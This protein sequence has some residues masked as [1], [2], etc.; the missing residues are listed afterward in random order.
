MGIFSRFMDIVNSNINSILD[1]AEDPEKM[2]R[3]MIQEMEDTLIELKSSC[4]GL[5]AD[6]IRQEKTLG[7]TE[8]AIERWQNRAVL[9]VEKGREDLA[10]E[11]LLEK[12][13]FTEVLMQKKETLVS[14]TQQA[15]SAKAEIAQLEDK[16]QDAKRKLKALKEKEL[17]AERERQ[18]NQRRSMD[19]NS[20]FSAMEDRIE[21]Q[22]AWNEVHRTEKSAEDRFAELEAEDEIDRELEALR[23]ELGK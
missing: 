9:A 2:L 4:A 6:A 11:A 12:K 17:E 5:M 1:K 22:N 18:R 10:R 8:K 14:M 19:L 15:E 7:E 13:K 23:K 16:L 21:R 3:L 20:Q